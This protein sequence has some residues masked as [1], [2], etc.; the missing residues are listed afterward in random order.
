MSSRVSRPLALIPWAFVI[1]FLPLIPLKILSYGFVPAGDARRHIA[2]AFTGASYADLLVMRPQYTMSQSPGWEWLLRFLHQKA[3]WDVDGLV[4]FSVVGLLLCIFFAPLPW[5]RRPEAWLAAL[6]AGMVA[7]PALMGRFAQARP[8]LV[9]EGV[10]I[11]LLFAWARHPAPPSLLKIVLTGVAIALSVWMHGAWYLWVLPLVAFF[12]ARQWRAG[13]WLTLCAAVGTLVGA[14]LTGHPLVFLN[15]ALWMALA[16]YQEHA[17]EWTLVGEFRPIQGAFNT[18]VLLVLVFLWRRQQNP[19]DQGTELRNP[20]LWLIVLSWILGFKADRFWT[21]WGIPAVL[22]WLTVQFENLMASSGHTAPFKRIVVSAL[23]AIPLFL[24]STSDAERRFSST[25]SEVFLD[26]RDPALQGWL[27]E[28]NGIFYSGQMNFFYNTFFRNPTAGWRYV[29]GFEPALMPVE[30]L[31]VYRH[32][33]WTR[34]ALDSYRPWINRMRPGDRLMISSAG[35]PNL[36][37]LE[38]RHV[39]G[40][41]WIGRPIAQ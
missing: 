9:T 1:A 33:Q 18:V 36:A 31:K 35:Q 3:G 20:V 32:I 6:L 16:V 39:A 12:F 40:G 11:A 21:D 23:V 37:D 25:L 17:P 5:L 41:L 38:W 27:P 2:M 14:S 29:L 24:H 30:D 13:A 28:P 22:V 8:F 19:D 34:G 10:L 4:R 7:I 26:A 15:Q